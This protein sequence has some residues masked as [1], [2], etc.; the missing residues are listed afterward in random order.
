MIRFHQLE[1]IAEFPTRKLILFIS[2]ISYYITSPLRVA[3]LSVL[4]SD[5]NLAGVKIHSITNLIYYST[6]LL[7]ISTEFSTCM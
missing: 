7:F 5:L 2:K 4:S 6:V 3:A 1:D